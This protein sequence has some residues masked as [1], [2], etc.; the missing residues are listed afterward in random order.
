MAS[1]QKVRAFIS[2]VF[3]IAQIGLFAVSI[4]YPAAG[5]LQTAMM[6]VMLSL[7]TT[8]LSSALRD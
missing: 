7:P 3:V 5:T 8:L 2:I 6:F 1:Y 4:A